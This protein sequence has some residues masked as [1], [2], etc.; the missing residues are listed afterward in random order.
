MGY[1]IP[2]G[3]EPFNFIGD[4]FKAILKLAPSPLVYI[5]HEEF[6]DRSREYNAGKKCPTTVATL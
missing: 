5:N 4:V 1:I 6:H 3:F 2:S